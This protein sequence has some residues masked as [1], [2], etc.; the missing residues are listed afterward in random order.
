MEGRHPRHVNPVQVDLDAGSPEHVHDCVPVTLLDVILEDH[1]VREPHSPLA[2][3]EPR[4][5]TGSP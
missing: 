2:G 5:H 4:K 3:I 1:L